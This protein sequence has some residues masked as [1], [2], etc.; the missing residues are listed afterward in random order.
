VIAADEGR[1]DA[2]ARA[3]LRCDLR[4]AQKYASVAGR[5]APAYHGHASEQDAPEQ[6]ARELR[7][8]SLMPH[9]HGTMFFDPRD[10]D[11]RR[12]RPQRHPA[13]QRG[14][15]AKPLTHAHASS[16]RLA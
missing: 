10:S 7:Y 2:S 1:V 12:P 4:P 13:A 15:N 14:F 5:R 8:V 6:P 9:T 3:R 16:R 11:K